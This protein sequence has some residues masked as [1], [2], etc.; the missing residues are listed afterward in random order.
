MKVRCL[1]LSF[2]APFI[3]IMQVIALIAA[4][5]IFNPAQNKQIHTNT[6]LEISLVTCRVASSIPFFQNLWIP[7]MVNMYAVC[8]RACAYCASNDNHPWLRLSLPAGLSSIS[9][10][11]SNNN[12]HLATFCFTSQSPDMWYLYGF[13]WFFFVGH[14]GEW[15]NVGHGVNFSKRNFRPRHALKWEPQGRYKMEPII[16]I[17]MVSVAWWQAEN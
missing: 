6:F 5:A 2:A 3:W 12:W 1:I 9:I 11:H 16:I 4:A 14:V 7:R 13:G 17:S 8:V 15:D 10:P